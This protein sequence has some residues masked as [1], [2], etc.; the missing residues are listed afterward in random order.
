MHQ[1]LTIENILRG[2]TARD[3]DLLKADLRE[4]PVGTTR[5]YQ[6][7][8]MLG[9]REIPVKRVSAT[10]FTISGHTRLTS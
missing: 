4:M 8:S 7:L 2:E 3:R 6:Q 9:G 5:T 10:H 1:E